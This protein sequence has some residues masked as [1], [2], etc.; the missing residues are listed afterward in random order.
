[1]AWVYCITGPRLYYIGSTT[2]RLSVREREH[3]NTLKAGR[4]KNRHLQSAYAK[5]GRQ[6]FSFR[7]LEECSADEVE[8]REQAWM[9]QFRAGG[10]RLYN[11]AP[12]AGSNRGC[13]RTAEMKERLSELKT[14]RPLSKEHV[15]AISEA[16]KQRIAEKGQHP[17]SIANLRPCAAPACAGYGAKEF[18]FISPEGNVVRGENL[19][20]FCRVRGLTLSAMSR[21]LSGR[22]NHHKGWRLY[23]TSN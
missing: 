2:R 22:A 21:V 14:G 17:N 18:A 5:Y 10:L 20:E 12:V 15:V 9:D 6:A 7:P 1:M 16:Q 13:V 19:S 11:S 4:H 8:N 23:G 3:W